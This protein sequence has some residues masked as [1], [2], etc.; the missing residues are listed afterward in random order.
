MTKNVR[1]TI[2]PP[3]NIGVLFDWHASKKRK[4]ELHLDRP[5]DIAPSGGVV[6]TADA[7]AALVR[8]V[9]SW[10]VA[11]G[12]EHGDRVAVI[13]QNHFDMV[14]IAA[15]AARIGA[16][17]ATISGANR[18]EHLAEML[19]KL[20]PRVSL[21]SRNVIE[22][23]RERD[24]NL[25][26][27]APII[28]IDDVVGFAP[29]GVTFLSELHGREIPP[30]S[31]RGD[32]EPMMI[33]HTSGTTSTPK[34]VVHSAN[35]ARAG[36]RL[37]LLP[38]PFAVNGRRDIA[39]SSISFAHSRAYAWAA[40]QLYWTPKKLV[41]ASKHDVA[42][43]E[44][45]FELHL[46]TTIEA[47]PN[48]FQGWVPLVHRR[49]ELFRRVRYYMNTFDMMHP[50]IARPFL[51]ASHRKLPLWAHSW[52]Q[53]EVGPIAGM[54]Y[55]RRKMAALAGTASDNMNTMGW[56]WPVLLR[57]RVVDPDT[58]ERVPRGKRGVLTVKT[59]SL[60][61]D[62]FGETGRYLS[63][64][65]GQW[66]NTGDVGYRDRLGRIRFVDRAVDVI[67]GMSATEI[68]S[69]LLERL[70]GAL[71]VI[72]LAHEDQEPVPVVCLEGELIPL[73]WKRATADLPRLALPVM[74]SWAD[75]PRTSTSKIRRK[76]LRQQ[77]FN[78]R[79]STA[80]DERFI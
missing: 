11:A 24:V 13:K 34:L 23:A 67:D 21:V 30:L 66:W 6:Y 50:S 70:P 43:V 2:L 52:G 38:L 39:L 36:T 51:S 28:L 35:S 42:Q 16:T 48:V 15:G 12:V 40:A 45:M 8:D 60:C 69:I 71:E 4:V 26:R 53:S 32:D 37:E 75:M 25:G 33:T 5:F 78:G 14:L 1:S 49:P 47:T 7:L 46:P 61:L 55:G 77:I 9:S 27:F 56:P 44:K 22:G 80:L 54:A 20:Q 17:A 62:Y 72:V 58:G 29:D 59:P 18:P 19:G 64:R 57:L 76:E 63:K 3:K 65:D 74:M 68:E 73:D 10:L 79:D 31:L 41:I